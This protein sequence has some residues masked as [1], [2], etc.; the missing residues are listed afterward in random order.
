MA[1][2]AFDARIGSRACSDLAYADRSAT[3]NSYITQVLGVRLPF[4]ASCVGAGH[5]LPAAKA[6]DQTIRHPNPQAAKPP[7]M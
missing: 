6:S 4:A 7:A 5:S 2:G 3:G 1:A